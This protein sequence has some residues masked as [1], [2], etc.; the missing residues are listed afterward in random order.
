MQETSNKY[1]AMISTDWNECLAPTGP[2]DP[3]AFCWPELKT[4]LEAIFRQYTG[5]IITL[6]QAVERLSRLLPHPLTKEQMDAYLD[7]HFATYKGVPDLI[8]WCSENHILFMI[9]TTA[10]IGFFQRIFA[11]GLLPPVAALSGHDMI[12]FPAENT[13][14]PIILPLHETSDKAINTQQVARRF[15]IDPYKIIII[16]DSGGDG[17]HFEWG[18]SQGCHLIGSMTKYSLQSYCTSRGINITTYFG[19]R[20][21]KDQPRDPRREMQFDFFELRDVIERVLLK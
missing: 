6:G 13:D 9:N 5:N 2:F 10:V 14:P 4:E 18:A 1:K 17:P 11:K 16:G 8:E 7:G 12:V 3:I 15:G 20:Y 19:I 21:D